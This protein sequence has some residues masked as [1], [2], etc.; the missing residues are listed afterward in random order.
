MKYGFDPSAYLEVDIVVW[1]EATRLNGKGRIKA[2][3]EFG[4]GIIV[5]LFTVKIH[6]L[7]NQV[8]YPDKQGIGGHHLR[9]CHDMDG[10]AYAGHALPSHFS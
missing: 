2:L 3:G 7:A 8:C 9:F 4:A 1:R 6:I 5:L 10:G